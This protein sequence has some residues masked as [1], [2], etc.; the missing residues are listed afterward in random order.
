M[1]KPITRQDILFIK[2]NL[3]NKG[4]SLSP[5]SNIIREY[6]STLTGLNTV[7][8]EAGIGHLL[9]DARIERGKSGTGHLLKFEYGYMNKDY[10]FH[11]YNVYENYCLTPPREQKRVNVKGNVN[12]T[13]C[14]QTIL[15]PDFDYLGKLFLND[16]NKKRVP[17]ELFEQGQI[18]SRTLAYWLLF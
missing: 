1:K 3:A 11:T 10:A 4:K 15:H 13:W 12:I 16:Q 6:K 18:T 5:N 9:G 14:F 7:Q 17:V 8:Q 2:E